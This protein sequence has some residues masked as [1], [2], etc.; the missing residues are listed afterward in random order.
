[1]GYRGETSVFTIWVTEVGYRGETS[2]FKYGLQRW[3]TE[4]KPLFLIYGLQRGYRGETSV[5]TVFNIS[6]GFPWIVLHI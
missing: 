5:F 1:V 6:K 4:V 3:V 2:V